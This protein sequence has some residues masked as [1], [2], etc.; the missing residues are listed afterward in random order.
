MAELI[1]IWW[2]STIGPF[3]FEFWEGTKISPIISIAILY[4]V[5]SLILPPANWA[6]NGGSWGDSGV[7]EIFLLT[8]L[9]IL[10]LLIVF[11]PPEQQLKA[12]FMSRTEYISLFIAAWF[13]QGAVN[14]LHVRRLMNQSD[15]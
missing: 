11:P 7:I 12:I 14:A 15:A 5:Y 9:F 3:D 4:S 1:V 8:S 13:A 6:I 2:A 10:P